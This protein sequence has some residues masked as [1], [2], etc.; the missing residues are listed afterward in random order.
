M[1]PSKL[2]QLYWKTR[3]Q[4][5]ARHFYAITGSMRTLPDFI[6]IGAM[7]SGT[8]SLYNYICEHPCVLPAAYDEVGFFDDNFHLGLNWYRSLF[9]TKKQIE[10]IRKKEGIAITGEDTPFYFWNKDAR[11]RIKKLLPE[12]KLVLILRNP[13]DR[14]FSEYNNVVR[15]KG[16]KLSFEEYIKPDLGNI[17]NN[18]L[19]VSQCGQKSAIISRGIYFIQLQMWQELF[20]KESIFIFDSNELSNKPVETMNKVFKFLNLPDYDFEKRFHIKKFGYGKMN[21]STREKLIEFY[22]P[23]NEKLF[24]LIGKKYNWNE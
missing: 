23:M 9:P 24:N 20:P 3:Y 4:L 18:P 7:K 13:V 22:R 12:I 15:E 16:V 14:A 5:L 21:D 6:I 1:S 2:K 11:D 19:N 8:T 10:N 17:E